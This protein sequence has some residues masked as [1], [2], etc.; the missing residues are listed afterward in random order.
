MKP[1]DIPFNI[2]LLIPTEN[3]T[4]TILPVT[5]L[6]TFEGMTKNFH[7]QGLYSVDI[8]GVVGTPS[9]DEKYAFIDIKLP[10]LHPVI[11]K[12]LVGLKS[13]YRDIMASKEFAIFD[14]E[15]R[16]FIKSDP[17]SGQTGYEFFIKHFKKLQF[18][19]RSS[20]KREQ[21]IALMEKYKDNCLTDKIIVIPASYRDIEV[22]PNG[23]ASSD[24]INSIYYKLLAVSNTIHP[25]TVKVAPESY[26]T[27][28]MTLQNA[29]LE[30]YE[31]INSIIDGKKNLMMGKWASRKVFNGTRNVITSANVTIT[32]LD[33][34]NKLT[35]N[36]TCIGLYQTLKA[37]LPISLYRL[38]NGIL[39]K[40]FTE[41]G[42]PVLLT[43]KKTL[44]SERVEVSSD[45]YNTWLTN[46]GLEKQIT[47]FK[48]NSIRHNEIDIDGYYL[49]LIYKGSDNTFKFISGIDELPEDR[50]KEDCYPITYTELFY[51]SIYEIANNYPVYVTRYPITGMG[52]IYPSKVYLKTT[53]EFEVRQELD[54][55][56][57][58]SGNVAK[59]FPI[60]TSSFFNSVAPSTSKL[61]KLGADF[62][63]DKK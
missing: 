13:L 45:S 6:D 8:F 14:E 54:D 26:N 23:R 16:D 10:I 5:S 61:A 17:I 46:E 18:E 38:K 22:D 51:L 19:Q 37:M 62:D 24:E 52:S 28:R 2:S 25:G 33:D 60:R 57:R 59:Q 35:V 41:V 15:Q 56:W 1:S 20:T 58:P 43:N 40:A 48:E 31:Y 30:L 27:Q 55:E 50:K 44:M 39:T 11:F 42:N 32:D 9:R 4:K 7:P 36:D 34:N 12:T 47:Y 63:G 53:V 3:W 29:F 21:S 49:G